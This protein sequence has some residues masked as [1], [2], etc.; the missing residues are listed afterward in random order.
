MQSGTHR[1]PFSWGP[2]TGTLDHSQVW[3][4]ANCPGV[5]RKPLVWNC[6][7]CLADY[8][9]LQLVF[10]TLTLQNQTA[11]VFK[12]SLH[13]LDC[14]LVQMWLWK[15]EK[16]ME[17][18]EPLQRQQVWKWLPSCDLQPGHTAPADNSPGPG[19]TEH[20]TNSVQGL[21]HSWGEII[22]KVR[23]KAWVLENLRARV[24][25]GKHS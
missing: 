18:S 17:G 3:N 22:A 20:S 9:I 25:C 4:K 21:V 6:H 23:E 7:E 10:N 14:L 1:L 16:E 24:I 2:G 12:A 5:R 11:P 8:G 19:D 13:R 15:T